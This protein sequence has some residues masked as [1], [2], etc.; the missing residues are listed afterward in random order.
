M[1]VGYVLQLQTE[2]ECDLYKVT[3]GRRGVYEAMSPLRH[4]QHKGKFEENLGIAS[5]TKG[6]QEH[7]SCAS[8]E[9]KQTLPLC[10]PKNFHAGSGPLCPRNTCAPFPFYR[11]MPGQSLRH[12]SVSGNPSFPHLQ[13]CT[14]KIPWGCF[15]KQGKPG[16]LLSD[17]P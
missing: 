3:K 12:V 1:I 15:C 10:Q 9:E 5:T 17:I 6:Q 14:S 4:G 7:L 16:F 2:R 13:Q 8:L 11:D